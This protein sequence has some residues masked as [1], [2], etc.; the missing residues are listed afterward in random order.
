MSFEDP[1]LVTWSVLIIL[2]LIFLQGIGLGLALFFLGKRISSMQNQATRL[3]GSI[4]RL[5]DQSDRLLV[6]AESLHQNI[7]G[8]MQK[9]SSSLRWFNSKMEEIDELAVRNLDVAAN[10]LQRV[11]ERSDQVLSGFGATTHKIHRA[12]IDP[13]HYISAALSA[14]QES[15]LWVFTRA[16]PKDR[17]QVHPDEQ[18]FI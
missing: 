3:G 13:A 5:L 17:E 4:S 10:Q 7:P 2:A 15:V 12:I 18:I 6:Q 16:R 14:I 1:A 9:V 11:S 8:S